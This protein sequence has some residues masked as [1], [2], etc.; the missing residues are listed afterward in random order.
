[1]PADAVKFSRTR[2]DLQKVWSTLEGAVI[3]IQPQM[4][5]V[6]KLLI[7]NA[8]K[9]QD[10]NF[11]LRKN[12]IGN[13]GDDIVTFH[14]EP[15]GQTLADLSKQ[16]SLTL[17]G[18]PKAEQLASAVK[19]IA[20]LMPTQGSKVKEREF[21]GRTLYTIDLPPT[22]SPD[23]KMISQKLTYV[24]SGGYVALSTD[25]AMVEEYLRGNSPKPLKATPGMAEA[26][27]RVGGMNAGMFGYENDRQSMRA[28]FEIMRKESGTLANLFNASP[29]AERFGMG[30]DEAKFKDWLDFSLLPSY[31][32]VMKYFFFTVYGSGAN[33]DGIFLKL[34]SPYPPGLR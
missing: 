15:R 10:P 33:S 24:A 12:L 16:P 13:L 20:S 21:L 7:D 30:G 2:L 6:I 17:I 31:D 14:K 18:S 3:E 25:T 29:L 26:A 5:G 23:K 8:G 22:M 1:V 19:A 28:V 27:E 32:S 9:D 11:D 4:A 34:F